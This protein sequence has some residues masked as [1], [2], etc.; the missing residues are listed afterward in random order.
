MSFVYEVISNGTTASITIRNANP[1]FARRMIQDHAD[2]VRLSS[3][4]STT[5]LIQTKVKHQLA[6]IFLSQVDIRFLYTVVG[7]IQKEAAKMFAEY[8]HD[9]NEPL[10]WESQW[11]KLICI[12]EI[13]FIDYTFYI[14]EFKHSLIKYS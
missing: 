11:I 8:E 13:E 5:P 14:Y 4:T 10:A 1:A 9:D 3:G 2:R 6:E 7:I 12:S